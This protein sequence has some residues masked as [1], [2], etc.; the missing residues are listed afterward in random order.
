MPRP[1]SVKPRIKA[2]KPP[3]VTGKRK[4]QDVQSKECVIC[5]ETK[6]VY[7][8]FPAFTTCSHDPD[9]CSSCIA[10]QTVTNLEAAQGTGWSACRCPQCNMTLPAEELQSALPRALVKEMKDMI[11]RTDASTD[12]RWRWCLA[13]GCGH[14]SLQDGRNEMIRCRKCDCK[15]CFKHQ[16]PWHKGY[17][18]QEYDTS[19]PQAA[20]TKTN[21]EMI[22]KMSKPCPG[23]GIAVEK[24]GGCSHMTC[25]RIILLIASHFLHSYLTICRQKMRFALELGRC[26]VSDCRPCTASNGVHSASFSKWSYSHAGFASPSSWH[27]HYNEHSTS[28]YLQR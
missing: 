14:G 20:I 23:C 8:K 13:S 2:P 18:C 21:E 12:D 16:V 25:K 22:K 11:N 19:H 4:R 7:R 1:R 3:P 24:I 26:F 28:A 15:M 27:D 9:T 5:I 10:K 6:P 17:T